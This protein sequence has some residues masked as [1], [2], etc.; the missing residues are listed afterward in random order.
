MSFARLNGV[1]ANVKAGGSERTLRSTGGMARSADGKMVDARRQARRIFNL[2][3]NHL[4]HEEA[5]SLALL[6][7]GYAHV[8]SF[9][10]SVDAS[11]SLAPT[12]AGHS[13]HLLIGGGWDGDA[14]VVRSGG[15]ISFDAQLDDEWTILLRFRDALLAGSP[16][17]YGV[18]THDGREWVDGVEGIFGMRNLLTISA[19]GIVTIN[20]ERLDAAAADLVCDELVILPWRMATSH[21]LDV[22]AW[23]QPWG[24]A[25]ELHLVGDIIESP[26][27][28]FC[29]GK[30]EKADVITRATGRSM[31]G[32]ITGPRPRSP[33]VIDDEFLNN[34]LAQDLELRETFRSAS[35]DTLPLPTLYAP[36]GSAFTTGLTQHERITTTDFTKV[37]AVTPFAVGPDGNPNTSSVYV[38]GANERSF[39][40]GSQGTA[41]GVNG[42]L[43][44]ASW[45]KPTGA[46]ALQTLWSKWVEPLGREWRVRMLATGQLEVT[47]SDG[48]GANSET[49]TTV[50]VVMSLNTWSFISFDYGAARPPGGRTRMFINGRPVGLSFASVG[51]FTAMAAAAGQLTIGQASPIGGINGHISQFACWG[52]RALLTEEQ[53]IVYLLTKRGH[54]LRRA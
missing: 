10:G 16:W 35:V 36:F 34:A 9:N 37:L 1:V 27:G 20:G 42:L 28:I 45:F 39:R 4:P 40:A 7:I 54:P 3:L 52:A 33:F 5:R 41:A 13:A 24:S 6:A 17:R 2:Q 12:L 32:G 48:V 51:A 22:M 18:I 47:V 19:S 43:T 49:Y 29:V 25:P 30:A 8:F 14:A 44:V 38:G 23:E 21:I 50:D 46:I 11:T 15:S 26:L 53:R 31:R